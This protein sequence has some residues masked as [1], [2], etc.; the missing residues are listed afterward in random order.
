MKEEAMETRRLCFPRQR[1]VLLLFLFG[2]VSLAA[3]RFRH[4]S[5][6]EETERGSFVVNL[7]KELGIGVEELATRRTRVVSDD[8]K[9]HLLLDSHT[10]NVLTNEK[11]DREKLC[12]SIE[13]CMLYF[14]IL[15]DN[16]FQIYRAELKIRD[17]NDHSPVFRE[18]EMVLKI[19]E[20]TAEGATFRLERA[21][22]SDRGLNGIQNYTIEPNSFF[23]I[24]IS[25]SD[26][27]TIYPELVLDKALDWE[28][29]PELNLTLTA[30]DGGSPPRSGITTIRILVLDVNDNAPKFSQLIYETQAPENSPLGSLVVK[31]SAEDADSGVNAEVTYSFFDA[32]EDIQTIFQINP[33][34][35][36]I[37]L[38]ALLDYE[39]V[40]SH[41]INVQAIDGGG[42]SARCMVL[43]QVLDTNDNPPE[44]IISS[45]SNYI[46]ENSPE[47]VLAVFRAKDRDSG[48]NGKTVCYIQDNL[49]FRLKPSVENF[50]ILMT[51]EAL[52]R[53]SRAEYNITI[54]VT[55]L[56]TPRLKTEHSIIILVSDVNDNAPAFTQVSYTLLV[57]E[58]NQP[59]MHIGSVSATDRDSGTNAQITYSLLTNQDQH[60]P[61]A[62][63]V[64][65]NANNGQL[66][67][68]RA[69][70]FEALQAFEFHVGATDQ[71]SPALS[72]QALVRVVVL[73]DND[74][75]PFVLYPMQNASAPCT[76]L[77]PRAAE[78]G[79]LVTKVVA[80]DGDSGQ[81]AWLSYQLLKATEPGLFG[82][83]AHNGEVR[84]SRL[85][86]E[87]DAARHR[88]VVLVKDNGEPPL[89][90]SVTLHVLLVDGFSQPYLPLPEVAPE[91]AQGDSLTVYLVIALASVSS[92][93]LFSVLV[94]VAV[95]VCRRRRAASLEVCSVP[96]GHF[97][98]HL[99][100][101]SGTGTLSQSYQY[102]VCLTG[103]SSGT[104]EFKFLKPIYPNIHSNGPERNSVENPIF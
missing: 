51:E 101:V 71:G 42:L 1:Q 83:W 63:L 59:A 35:G 36:E 94:F 3:N 4:Y 78:Q 6:T 17:I 99:V 81:N 74:N 11:L 60:L 38:K 18:K 49:P 15:M 13:P 37:I 96:E 61:L 100:D 34:S 102:K 5:V 58:N 54:T 55:D 7:A 68:L 45:L 33:F 31:V 32:D 70:D 50:Y 73:D 43:V 104:S 48:E 46:D 57:R 8:N 47:T 67:A 76:E 80:V 91:R 44:L 29:Q 90:A 56:G 89:S 20:N 9:Q 52:D 39:L 77:V 65:I 16:P 21:Q 97:P 93:F 98:G 28:K 62:S 95:R 24:T 41:K 40:K 27:G 10:G 22:D 2:G 103:D 25:D 85:L 87:R 19:L 69:L 53:E 23:H 66:F 75:S 88:L 79:Y 14:Q 84:T 12:G 26:E 86:S 72:S 64:S 92:L 82:V 30:L